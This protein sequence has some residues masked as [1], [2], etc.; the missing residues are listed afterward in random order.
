MTDSNQGR[1]DWEGAGVGKGAI[2]R[3]IPFAATH[4]EPQEFEP[5]GL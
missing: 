2:Q 4:R 3:Q 1:E 5:T